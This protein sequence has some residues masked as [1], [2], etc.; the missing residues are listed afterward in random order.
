MFVN[1]DG[2]NGVYTVYVERWL[3]RVTMFSVHFWAYWDEHLL[4]FRE[5]KEV[6]CEVPSHHPVWISN[7]DI[8]ATKI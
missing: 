4:G 7:P 2:V 1:S 5:A 6:L 3:T 8:L